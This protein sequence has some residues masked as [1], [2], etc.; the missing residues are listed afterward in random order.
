MTSYLKILCCL[1]ILV[2]CGAT[3]PQQTETK[4]NRPDSVFPT[5]PE[6]ADVAVLPF[7]NQTG[8]PELDFLGTTISATMAVGLAQQKAWSV[9][10]GSLVR[11]KLADQKWRSAA[12]IEEETAISLSGVLRVETPI[13]GVFQGKERDLTVTATYISGETGKVIRSV[14][15]KARNNDQFVLINRLIAGLTEEKQPKSAMASHEQPTGSS[16]PLGPIGRTRT[17]TRTRI[18]LSSVGLPTIFRMETPEQIEKS[19]QIYQRALE[20][21]PN[22]AEAYFTLGYAYDRQGDLDKAI[23]SYRQ[24]VM[25]NPLKS[26]YLYLLGYTYERKKELSQAI[27]AYEKA[28]KITS[29]ADIAFSLGY[30]HEQMGQYAESTK[31][32]SQAIEMKP[33][34]YDAYYGLASAYEKSGRLQEALSSFQQVV[35][36]KPDEEVPIRTLGAIAHK[37]ARWDEV[38][39]AFEWLIVQN[40][41]E[42]GSH[43]ILASAYKAKGQDQKLIG[44]YTEIIR[45]DPSSSVAYTNL[46]NI[47][48]R[49]K[50]YNKGVSQY[51]AGIKATPEF[52]L[53]HYNLGSRFSE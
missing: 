23:A 36:L 5:R 52:E 49:L 20:T 28:L 46:G 44:A 8:D 24:A 31:A 14:T 34:D 37:M 3:V 9:A 10:G 1:F 40:P 19:I 53:L 11:E 16:L 41:D 45:L 47:Y 26:D 12:T 2:G 48:V 13:T 38:I 27:D 6:P 18:D 51:R 32:F 33:D 39:D 17:R 50:D 43:R 29:D 22:F 21:D 35:K 25:L 4:V 7:K 15:E 30:V 42:V